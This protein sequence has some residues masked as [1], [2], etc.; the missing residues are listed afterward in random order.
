ME[1]LDVLQHLR[2]DASS[3]EQAGKRNIGAMAEIEMHLSDS[4]PYFGWRLQPLLASLLLFLAQ[5]G[6]EL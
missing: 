3:A 1:E 6:V 2:L 5:L 4:L